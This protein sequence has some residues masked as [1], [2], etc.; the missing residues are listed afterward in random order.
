MSKL[1]KTNTMIKR[2]FLTPDR[3]SFAL[4]FVLSTFSIAMLLARV[5]FSG[6]PA[7][8]FLIWNLFLAWLPLLFALVASR[9]RRNPVVLLTFGFLWLLFLPNAPYLITDLMHL[10]PIGPVPIWYDAMMLFSFALSGLLLGLRSLFSMQRIVNGRFGLLA[11]WVFV[12][13]ACGLSS[14]GI[15]IGRFLR[16]NSWDIFAHPLRLSADIVNSLTDPFLL[17]KAMVVVLLF[18]AVTLGAYLF[19]QLQGMGQYVYRRG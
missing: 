15:Y 19:W 18:S 3:S 2:R 6:Q 1:G 5:R 4:L 7:H 11:G 16:W 17:V 12:L 10:R 14:F 8:A 13:L 9:Y